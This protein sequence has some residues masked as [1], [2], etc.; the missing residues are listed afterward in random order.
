[1]DST[2][3]FV[4]ILFEKIHKKRVYEHLF[5]EE[6]V[7]KWAHREFENSLNDMNRRALKREDLC[8]S[9]EPYSNLVG[10]VDTSLSLKMYSLFFYTVVYFG[11]VPRTFS[12][13]LNF[14]NLYRAFTFF[15]RETIIIYQKKSI[16]CGK[17]NGKRFKLFT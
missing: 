6:S 15:R 4:Y 7:F 17:Y 10:G 2:R 8:A 12:S 16:F 13:K 3:S 1:M 11:F 9:F 5:L 14:H